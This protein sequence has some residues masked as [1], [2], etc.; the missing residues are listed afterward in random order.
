[1]FYIN[2]FNLEEN[3]TNEHDLELA[4]LSFLYFVTDTF[5]IA[6][7]AILSQDCTD[8]DYSVM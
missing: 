3:L 1:M 7:M 8:L 5:S 4:L 6:L 2:T